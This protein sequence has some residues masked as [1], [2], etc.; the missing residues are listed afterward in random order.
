MGLREFFEF[1][2]RLSVPEPDPEAVKAYGALH[3]MHEG[4]HHSRKLKGSSGECGSILALSFVCLCLWGHA[5]RSDLLLL[6]VLVVVVAVL[7]INTGQP[8]LCSSNR[9][10]NNNYYY[11]GLN[12]PL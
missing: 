8:I 9:F 6:V 1:Y 7:V 11:S 10:N 2:Q 5:L 4:H 3:K 12:T